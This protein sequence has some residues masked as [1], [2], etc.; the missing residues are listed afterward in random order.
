MTENNILTGGDGG[1]RVEMSKEHY[2]VGTENHSGDGTENDSGYYVGYFK[3]RGN[4]L[5]FEVNDGVGYVGPE[6]LKIN[7]CPWCGVSLGG[8]K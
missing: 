6:E 7:F 4:I 2:C 5:S 8:R 1:G 3:I